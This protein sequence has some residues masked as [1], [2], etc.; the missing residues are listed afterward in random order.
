ME[1]WFSRPGDLGALHYKKI[2]ALGCCLPEFLITDLQFAVHAVFAQQLAL[3]CYDE[4]LKADL[5]EPT[6]HI[7]LIQKDLDMLRQKVHEFMT[8]NALG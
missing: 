5:L 4:L 1:I 6:V 8:S 2:V 7:S 3:L